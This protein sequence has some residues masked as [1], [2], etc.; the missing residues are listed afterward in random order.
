[1][2]DLVEAPV[3]TASNRPTGSV[4]GKPAEGNIPVFLAFANRLADLVRPVA[5]RHFRRA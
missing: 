2:A 4:P 5:R 3:I 1:L